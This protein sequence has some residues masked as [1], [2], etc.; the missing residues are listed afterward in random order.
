[1]LTFLHSTEHHTLRNACGN[2]VISNKGKQVSAVHNVNDASWVFQITR[3]YVF[4]EIMCRKIFNTSTTARRSH[5]CV[6]RERSYK[7][8]T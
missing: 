4:V 6:S 2:Q 1:M 7:K 3:Q 8:L 5:N